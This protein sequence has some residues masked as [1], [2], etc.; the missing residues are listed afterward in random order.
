MELD[1]SDDE[2]GDHHL[3]SYELTACHVLALYV[4]DRGQAESWST[5]PVLRNEDDGLTVSAL[6]NWMV[7]S[8]GSCVETSGWNHNGMSVYDYRPL[9][10][11]MTR[12]YGSMKRLLQRSVSR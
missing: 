3:P 1:G 4:A 10:D 11:E 9:S 5:A 8:A 7:S 12:K 6:L 2:V